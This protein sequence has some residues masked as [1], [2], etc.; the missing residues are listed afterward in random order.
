MPKSKNDP[1][2]IVEDQRT[3][4]ENTS[5]EDDFKNMVFYTKDGNQYPK[6]CET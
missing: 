3:D 2:V 1:D 5:D 4:D 6:D